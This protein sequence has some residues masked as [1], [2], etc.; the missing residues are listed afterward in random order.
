MYNNYC[1][2]RRVVTGMCL[3]KNNAL[4][5]QR[6]EYFDSLILTLVGDSRALRLVRDSVVTI[7]RLKAEH[8]LSARQLTRDV[9]VNLNY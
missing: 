4:Q 5:P 7:K 3:T 6:K 1:L 2:Y 9:T 8:S